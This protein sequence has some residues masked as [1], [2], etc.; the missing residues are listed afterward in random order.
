MPECYVIFYRQAPAFRSVFFK[1]K[2]IRKKIPAD[3]RQCIRKTSSMSKSD[4]DALVMHLLDTYG[5]NSSGPLATL[6][7]QTVSERLKTPASKVK[8]MRYDAALKF[9]G[10]IEDQAMG[11]LLA[12]LSKASLEPEGEKVLLIIEDSL[13]KNWL[14]GQ[15]KIHQSHIP[16]EQR[17]PLSGDVRRQNSS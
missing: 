1:T 13:A 12:A 3:C 7:N 5:V 4:I 17:L 8:K 6:S 16:R 9:G 2:R 14:Q 15:L 10:R 11:R